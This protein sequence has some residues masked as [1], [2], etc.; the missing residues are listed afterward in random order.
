MFGRRYCTAPRLAEV[1]QAKLMWQLALAGW[2]DGE[3]KDKRY[4]QKRQVTQFSP[5]RESCP[6]ALR[7]ALDPGGNG[8]QEGGEMA[9][10]SFKIQFLHLNAT[11]RF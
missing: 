3:Q 6:A 2:T 4:T 5:H 9:I 11:A 1:E 8:T 10:S 7:G